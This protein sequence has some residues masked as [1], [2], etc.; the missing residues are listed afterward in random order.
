MIRKLK[1]RYQ[2]RVKHVLDLEKQ[3]YQA[4]YAD[5]IYSTLLSEFE[6]NEDLEMLVFSYYLAPRTFSYYTCSTPSGSH[7][8]DSY[9][10]ITKM[11]IGFGL[12]HEC[13]RGGIYLTDKGKT[14]LL[15][16]INL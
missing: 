3:M 14:V 8:I 1:K 7:L 15:P 2:K 11:V 9:E 13:W 10:K 16:M 5:D 6:W 4:M 12:G